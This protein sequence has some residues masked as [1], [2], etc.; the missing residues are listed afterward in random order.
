MGSF[1]NILSREQDPNP[2]TDLENPN[3]RKR[4]LI[5]PQEES[6]S[7]GWAK[8][9]E[10]VVEAIVSFRMER[11]VRNGEK[12]DELVYYEELVSQAGTQERI[13]SKH[14]T[15]SS[16]DFLKWWEQEKGRI[17]AQRSE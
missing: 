17:I 3:F 2:V 14:L 13:G 15:L 9:I 8:H 4:V 6:P 10:G 11:D 12:K 7:Q 5:A 1:R 16:A